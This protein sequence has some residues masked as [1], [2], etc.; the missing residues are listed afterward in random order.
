[1]LRHRLAA[2]D[3]DASVHRDG[4]KFAVRREQAEDFAFHGERPRDGRLRI[5]LRQADGGDAVFP[6]GV[7]VLA[8]LDQI[9]RG[10]RRDLPIDLFARAKLP[11]DR[12]AF[13]CFR[14]GV[15]TVADDDGFVADGLRRLAG[16][17]VIRAD[18]AQARVDVEILFTRRDKGAAVALSA[19]VEVEMNESTRLA[20]KSGRH[21]ST[22]GDDEHFFRGHERALRSHA[23]KS[24]RA[25]RLLDELRARAVIDPDG[26]SRFRIQRV[27]KSPHERPD[28]GGK[29]D[30]PVANHRSAA[31]RPRGN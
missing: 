4:D 8:G 24:R 17:Q 6:S 16:R 27:K 14:G 11:H 21:G 13:L 15:E 19:L 1:M 18:A 12:C 20:I 22:A 28:A 5:P 30:V 31:C 26:L 2:K 7:K 25:V 23:R 10:I 9:A 29:I 3:E